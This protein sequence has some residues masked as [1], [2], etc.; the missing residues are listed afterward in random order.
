MGPPSDIAQAAGL[1]NGTP[2]ATYGAYPH[3]YNGDGL[4][5]VLIN[6]HNEPGGPRLFRND[7]GG[8]FTHV[9]A[10]TFISR[11]PSGAVTNDRHGCAWSD[12]SRD[13]LGDFYCTMGA[14]RGTV[15]DKANEL[16]IQQPGGGFTNQAASYG[17]TDPTGVGR[18]AVFLNA[19][20]DT[21]PDRSW[22]SCGSPKMISLSRVGDAQ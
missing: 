16:W 5:D 7:G 6:P 2:F 1:Y 11:R 18:G 17:V 12:V 19:N 21:L 10:G 22:A 13:G 3:D 8:H 4:V 9:L 15:T 20:G 14:N